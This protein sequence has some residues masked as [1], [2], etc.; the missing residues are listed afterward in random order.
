[1]VPSSKSGAISRTCAKYSRVVWDFRSTIQSR[2]TMVEV[3]NRTPYVTELK[4]NQNV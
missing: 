3:G 1:M 4:F 2:R